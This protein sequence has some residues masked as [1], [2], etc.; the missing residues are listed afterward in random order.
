MKRYCLAL[1]L[2]NDPLLINEY[3]AQTLS[4]FRWLTVSERI[5]EQ[6]RQQ[7]IQQVGICPQANDPSLI[8]WIKDNWE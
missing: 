8:A 1:D 5:A 3:K 4:Q 2:V 7:G 6:L